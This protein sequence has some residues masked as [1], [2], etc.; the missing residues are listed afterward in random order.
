M[1]RVCDLTNKRR[2]KINKVSIERS[3][4][5]K[6]HPTFSN[7]NLQI[8]RYEIQGTPYTFRIANST[9]RTI[10]KFGDIATYLVSV[11]RHTLSELALKLRKKLYVKMEKK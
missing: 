8:V 1:S 5:T 3:Q 4:I 11:K 2:M 10:E 7:V 9:K 6:R